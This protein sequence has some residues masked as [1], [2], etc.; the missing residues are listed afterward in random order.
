MTKTFYYLRLSIISL[1]GTLCFV[2]VH[3]QIVSAHW[4]D[5]TVADIMVENTTAQMTLTILTNLVQF[6]DENGN[7]QISVSEFG[8]HQRELEEVFRDRISFKN[9]KSDAAKL[10]LESVLEES[11]KPAESP[12]MHS[13]FLL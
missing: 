9:T 2:G 12:E 8:T 10:T 5:L 1:L 11:A 7:G 13:T 4:A 3:T 6:A